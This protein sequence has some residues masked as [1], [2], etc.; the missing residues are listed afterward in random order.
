MI[1]KFIC[2]FLALISLA[3][4]ASCSEQK[5]VDVK[6]IT[7]GASQLEDVKD[8]IDSALDEADF[9]GGAFVSL[10]KNVIYDDYRGFE[11]KDKKKTI[12]SSTRYQFSSLTKNIT[13][14][15]TLQLAD[16]K[17]LSLDDT[18][19][20]F[21]EVTPKRSYLKKTTVDQLLSFEV[22]L[23]N[24][25]VEIVNDQKSYKKLAETI[26]SGGDVKGLIREHILDHGTEGEKSDPNSN[27][28]LLGLIIEKVSG[29][30]YKDYIQKN[31][32]DRL[33]MTKTEVVSSKRP[34]SGYNVDKKEWRDENTTP[35]FNNYDFMF[36]SFGVTSVIGDMTRFFDAIIKN[37]LTKTN[38]IDEIEGF[39]TNYGYGFKH[40]GRNLFSIGGTSLH[41]SY[42]YIN[43]ETEELVVLCSNRTGNIKLTATGKAVYNAVNSKV[44][45]ILL[46]N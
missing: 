18:L 32:F 34:L 37:S 8:K 28:Y 30:S 41:S 9:S 22:D 45:G 7:L 19:D 39:S 20:N 42:A 2:A 5:T 1:K 44:N 43:T 12:G 31:I 29:E 17:K 3:S 6:K 4:F 16:A 13:G 26:N 11:S 21:F 15:A 40:D 25:A 38:I 27:Y 33:K 46:D 35:L 10:N 24:Y 36:S 14:V 23:G